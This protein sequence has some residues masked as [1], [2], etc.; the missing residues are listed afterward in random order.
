LTSR[1]TFA[2]TSSR[3]FAMSVGHA[4]RFREFGIIAG[5][6]GIS[7]FCTL[8]SKSALFPAISLPG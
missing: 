6:F 2:L 4:E 5:S 8:T 1:S 3:I 7:T